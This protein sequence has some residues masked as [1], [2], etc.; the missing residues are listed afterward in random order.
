MVENQME[1]KLPVH[2]FSKIWELAREVVLFFWNFV[3]FSEF[4]SHKI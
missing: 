1:Q 3:E 2:F 4:W